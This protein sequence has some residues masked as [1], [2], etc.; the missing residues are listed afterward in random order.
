MAS[1]RNLKKDI[2]FLATELLSEAYVKQIIGENV[3]QDAL[4]K[5]MVQAVELRNE[6]ISRANHP[7]A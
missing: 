4:A 6:L 7:N 1:L 2:N 3:D 5:L